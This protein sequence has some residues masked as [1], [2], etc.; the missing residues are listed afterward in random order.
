LLAKVS[1]E[2]RTPLGA[3]MGYAEMLRE[4]IFGSLSGEQ[5]EAAAEVI[6]SSHFL[7]TMVNE[8][9][10][11]AQLEAG[12]VKLNVKEMTPAD[13]LEQVKSKLGVLAQAK[14]LALNCTVEAAVPAVLC[15]DPERLQQIL[16]NLAGNA[17][18]FTERGEVRV[19]L[20]RPD[21]EHWAM[22]VVDTGA[23]IPAEAKAYIFEPFRQVDSSLTRLHRGT[24]L[25]LSIV[26]QLVTLMDGQIV[27]DSEVGRGSVFT[28]TLP[29]VLSE[30][31]GDEESKQLAVSSEQ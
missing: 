2:L 27:V 20:F 10:D 4:G 3:I 25:G 30:D 16:I 23:G 11:Q 6:D 8:L 19:E 12:R 17:I 18:K 7:T 15:G 14:G 26:K 1:H 31:G 13:L 29:L 24:G 9:L 5:R 21:E 28:I 22:R